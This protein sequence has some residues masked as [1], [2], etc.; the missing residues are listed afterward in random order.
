VGINSREPRINRLRRGKKRLLNSKQTW[1]WLTYCQS[2]INQ[3]WFFLIQDNKN[4]TSPNE[5]AQGPQGAA[6]KDPL[7][8]EGRV[9]TKHPNVPVDSLDRI[10]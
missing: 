10:W 6:A 2:Q 4:G 9:L 3:H 8:P 5:I 1:L 7:Q